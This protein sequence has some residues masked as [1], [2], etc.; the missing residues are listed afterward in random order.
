MHLED[1][2]LKLVLQGQK[3]LAS[4]DKGETCLGKMDNLN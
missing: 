1:T 4:D 3:K 2:G